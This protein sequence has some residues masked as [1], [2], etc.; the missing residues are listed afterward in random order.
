MK[1]ESREYIKYWMLGLGVEDYVVVVEVVVY[2]L[3]MLMSVV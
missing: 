3:G 1:E 2:K